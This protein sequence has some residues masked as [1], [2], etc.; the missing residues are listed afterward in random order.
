MKNSD[1]AHSFFYDVNGK[2]E[3]RS[4]TVFYE[5]NKYWSY[6][7]VIGKITETKEGETVC[8]LSNDNFSNTTAKHINEL[9][10]ACPYYTIYYL[11]QTLGSNDFYPSE[12]IN[13]C[14]RN[15]K[16]YSEA[17]LTQKA[18]RENFINYFQML[19][20]TLNLIDFEN[21]FDTITN[22]L[23]EYQELY[24]Q[25]NDPEKLKQI[26][27]LQIKRDKEKQIKLKNEL[28]NL[29]NQYDIAEL[30]SIAY[31]SLSTYEKELKQKLK[32][33]LNPKNE[34]SFIWFNSV[35]VETSQHIRVD[36]KE[37]EALL[38]LWSKGKLKHG[39]KISYYT[40]LEV[41]EKYIKVGCHKIPTENLQALIN[42]MNT[43]KAA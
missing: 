9:R 7:T 39:M 41:Q 40:V 24:N 29:L 31:S 35:Y 26:K 22:I 28:Q 42:Q 37:A 17:K 4:M 14:E 8:I 36:R 12:I 10:Q 32:Q 21:S 3:R 27:A 11:P 30:A 2:F 20:N 23:K 19:Q 33:Y 6:G 34:L 43:N 1:V 25:I 18:N 16:F 13:T 5:Y 15:L 38:K